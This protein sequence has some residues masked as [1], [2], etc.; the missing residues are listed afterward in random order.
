M[1]ERLAKLPVAALL[2]GP[3]TVLD[4]MSRNLNQTSLTDV[5]PALAGTVLLALAFWLAAV[6]LRRRVDAGA[7]VIACI[8]VAGSVFYLQIVEDLNRALGGG[9]EL[10]RP[11]PIAL[12]VMA[13]LTWLAH[14]WGRS[15]G[16]VHTVLIGIAAVMVATPAWKAA[17]YEIRNGDARLA[18]DPDRAE[19]A[20]PQVAG[21]LPGGAAR[22]PDIYHFIFDRYAS[23]AVLSQHYGIEERISEYLEERGFYVAGAS[24]SNYLKTGH[25]L[26]ST[27]YMDYLTNLADDPRVEKE[28]WH[29]IFKMLDDHRVGRFLRNRGYEQHQYGSWW[30][31]TFRNPVADANRPMGFSEFNMIYLRRTMATPLFHLLPDSPFTMRLDWDNG[32]CQRVPRQVEEIKRIGGGERPAYVF[33]HILVPHGPEVF[34]TDGDCL[35]RPE[36][37][38]RGER[39]GYID[40]VAYANAIIR[41]VVPA[42]QADDR[43]PAI[44]IIQAD[45]GPFPRR[46]Y[47][48]PWQE[49]SAEELHIK[50]G[51]LNAIYFPDGNYQGFEP[52]VSPVNTYRMVFNHVFDADLPLL[53]DR[54]MAFSSDRQIYDF[55]DVT[56]RVRCEADA[57]AAGDAEAAARC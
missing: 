16:L 35:E 47:R 34:T 37:V 25:S 53:P 26:A 32:Q 21:P 18:Y 1:R 22:P 23:E 45:E 40:Q 41:D 46:D 55:H 31:G 43:P 44:I 27:F 29:P 5:L 57:E 36:A 42:L 14:R 9:Y 50:T 48:V 15:L 20:M 30:V 6:A 17:A 10:V 49:A 7:A 19:A 4:A 24:H 12:A 54:T 38:A 33:A 3:A 28:T 51:I 13:A 56:D 39:Q 8:W 11:L 52:D 2:L